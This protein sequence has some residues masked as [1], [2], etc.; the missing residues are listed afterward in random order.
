M[1]HGSRIIGIR[2]DRHILISFAQFGDGG[3]QLAY[4]HALS[5]AA[6]GGY[7]QSSIVLPLRKTQNRG[8]VPAN[9]R[10]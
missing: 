1:T 8:Y 9:E 10:N 7:I 3:V 5:R 6:R 2:A 4:A